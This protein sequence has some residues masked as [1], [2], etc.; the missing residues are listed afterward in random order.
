MASAEIDGRSKDEKLLLRGRIPGPLAKNPASGTV[1]AV[2]PSRS[3]SCVVS[4]SPMFTG[5]FSGTAAE[6]LE[7]VITTIGGR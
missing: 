7:A 2:L 5:L 1:S 3:T 6:E 4:P